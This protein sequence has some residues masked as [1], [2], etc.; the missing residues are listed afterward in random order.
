VDLNLRQ[1]RTLRE[2]AARGSIAAA[3]ASLGYTPSAVSQ[4]LS[5]LER[6][7][8]L[9]LLERVG[10]GVRLTHAGQ[11]L[12]EHASGVFDKLEETRAVLEHVAGA[13][14]GP[15]RV[16]VFGSFAH[17]LLPDVVRELRGSHPLVE[18]RTTELEP[19]AAV[20]ALM[21]GS[22]DLALLL[23]YP[24]APSPRTNGHRRITVL[25]EPFRLAAPAGSGLSGVVD[26]AEL[27][28]RPW[29]TG[30][31]DTSCWRCLVAACRDAGFEP[32]IAH[33]IDNTSA[34]LELVAAGG[35]ITLLPE[36]GLHGAPPEVEVFDIAQPVHRT[37]EL[38]HRPATIGRPAV[39]AVV[40]A[41]TS[42]AATWQARRRSD[43]LAP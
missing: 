26:L 10:R 27:A 17:A 43:Q 18:L 37:I 6:A 36:L 9:E 23:D 19:D 20:G 5:A 32:D 12:A 35:G 28:D 11:V 21:S 30:L 39:A 33:Q 2:V 34:T 14:Q 4:Q 31:T 22:V 15:V 24:H 3:A 1:L 8:G 38:A 25:H 42:A 7:A 16:S 13:P 29:V 40:D 41:V